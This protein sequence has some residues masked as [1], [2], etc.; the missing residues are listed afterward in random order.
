[1]LKKGKNT[2]RLFRLNR[3]REEKPKS[4]LVL[5]DKKGNIRT[6][7]AKEVLKE[8]GFLDCQ[9]IILSYRMTD[10]HLDSVKNFENIEDFVD[11]CLEKAGD[12]EPPEN[13][14]WIPSF[15][16]KYGI[17]VPSINVTMDGEG[18]FLVMSGEGMQEVIIIPGCKMKEIILHPLC[19]WDEQESVRLDGINGDTLH[20]GVGDLLRTGILL[21]DIA[22]FAPAIFLPAM[23]DVARELSVDRKSIHEDSYG[24]LEKATKKAFDA[25]HG[26][27]M[28]NLESVYWLAHWKSHPDD[29]NLPF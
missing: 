22:K 8:Q 18:A 15:F 19:H 26:N 10:M 16:E 23:R 27:I 1:M 2:E 4:V 24:I 5:L 3:I 11:D 13:G 9:A 25:M 28:E 29:E 20:Y 12:H 14:C 6:S 7:I 21:E 17:E